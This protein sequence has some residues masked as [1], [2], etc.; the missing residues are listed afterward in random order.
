MLTLSFQSSDHVRC[1]RSNSRGQLMLSFDLSVGTACG[2]RLDKADDQKHRGRFGEITE[3]LE[4][5]DQKGV[6]AKVRFSDTRR[7]G[8]VPLKNLVPESDL[9]AYDELYGDS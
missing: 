2:I 9:D 4:K 7:V 5:D 3:F 8:I 6:R 1:S